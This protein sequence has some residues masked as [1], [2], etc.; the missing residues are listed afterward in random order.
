MHTDTDTPMAAAWSAELLPDLTTPLARLILALADDELITGH[1]ASHWTGVAPALESD[2][3]FSS[4]AQDE[5][6]HADVWYSLLVDREAADAR[7]RI[8][9][10][11]L[12]RTPSQYRHAVLCERPPGDFVYSLARHWAYD[13][14]DVVRLGALADSSHPDV[15]AVAQK[16][17]HEERY[18][19]MHADHWFTRLSGGAAHSRG[20]TELAAGLTAVL[21]EALWLFEPIEGEDELVSTGL[22]P[23]SSHDLRER[24]LEGV[25]SAIT[26]AGLEEV[27]PAVLRPTYAAAGGRRGVHSADFDL[28]VWPEMTALHRAHPGASW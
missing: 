2:L 9:A 24:W 6:N 14:A 28:D 12:G 1:R 20:R 22:L 17:L 26:A 27:L 7:S 3:A 15:A 8:D 4:I 16:L 13:H 5:I 23:V 11:G 25:T 10:I 21:P 18:H 19:L